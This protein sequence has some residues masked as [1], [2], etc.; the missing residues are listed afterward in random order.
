MSALS[1][2]ALSNKQLSDGAVINDGAKIKKP[3]AHSA[4]FYAFLPTV[5]EV[6]MTQRCDNPADHLGA[7]PTSAAAFF[8]F[9]AGCG[10]FLSF[11]NPQ[12]S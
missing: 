8:S 1:R 9:L 6:C 11:G 3:K 10:L 12:L 2:K 7:V 5:S 4:I